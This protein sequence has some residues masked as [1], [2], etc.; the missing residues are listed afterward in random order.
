MD[1]RMFLHSIMLGLLSQ[2]CLFKTQM[3]NEMPHFK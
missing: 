1:E 2:V 3:L